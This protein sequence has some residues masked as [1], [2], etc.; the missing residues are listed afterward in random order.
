MT[1]SDNIPKKEVARFVGVSESTIYRL[2]NNGEFPKSYLIGGR[3]FW[4]KSEVQMWI[5]KIKEQRQF[6]N[7]KTQSLIKTI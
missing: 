5:N 4:S 6:N 3:T 7:P 2:V 1:Y